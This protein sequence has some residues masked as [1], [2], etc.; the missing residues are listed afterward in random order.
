VGSPG[1][2]GTPS[3]G[4]FQRLCEMKA[5]VPPLQVSKQPYC[6][7]FSGTAAVPYST[8][9]DEAWGQMQRLGGLALRCL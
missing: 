5:P 2:R 1:P 8:A 6:T 4:T 9:I 7:R 3:F